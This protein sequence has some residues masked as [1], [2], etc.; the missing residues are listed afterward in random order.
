MPNQKQPKYLPPE[1]KD[2]QETLLWR[3][4]RRPFFGL[5]WSFTTYSLYPERLVVQ[6]GF[7]TR[8]TEEIRLYRVLDVS[9]KQGLF[10]RLFQLGSVK[11]TTADPSAPKLF[12]HD[13]RKSEQVHR[14][15]SDISENQRKDH[16]VT[17]ME[18]F[19]E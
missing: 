10:Q 15:V 4:K 5:P 16:Q 18:F 17:A 1:I 7:L 13:I 9:L 8:Q 2:A 11:V 14:L 12:L 6:K 19:G 3:D